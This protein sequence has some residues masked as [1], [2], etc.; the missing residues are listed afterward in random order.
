MVSKTVTGFKEFLLRGN[1]V[2]LAVAVIMG[3]TFG[4]VVT[5]FTAMLMDIIG[6]AG[7]VPDFSSTSVAGISVGAFLTALLTF[8]LTAVVVYF[9]VVIP[10]NKFS[11][12][13]KKDEPET[14]ASAEDLLAE[15][16]DLLKAQNER[17]QSVGP[18]G[19][20]APVLGGLSRRDGAG[21]PPAAVVRPPSA[22]GPS[23]RIAR[24]W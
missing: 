11:D 17:P 16:R 21:D 8:V 19:T 2:E 4:A 18:T 24:S 5:A 10:Y 12:L 9:A 14:A 22:P 20:D 23:P 13:R 1:L 3:T 15:I 6:K 7:G